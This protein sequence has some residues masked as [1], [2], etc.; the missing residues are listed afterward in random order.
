M[1][2]YS[3]MPAAK[4]STVIATW[5]T[6]DED[7]SAQVLSVETTDQAGEVARLLSSISE[8]AWYATAWLDA[9]PQVEEAISSFVGSLRAD[10]ARVQPAELD[11]AS[12]RHGD[13][14]ALEWLTGD[15]GDHG[16]DVLGRLNRAQRLSVADELVADAEGRRTWQE[17]RPSLEHVSSVPDSDRVWQIATVPRYTGDGF[18]GARADAFIRRYLNK[19]GSNLIAIERLLVRDALVRLD[20]LADACERAGGRFDIDEL[21]TYLRARYR[22]TLAPAADPDDMPE[23]ESFSVTLDDRPSRHLTIRRDRSGEHGTDRGRVDARD[24]DALAAAMGDW[25]R[26]VPMP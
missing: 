20:A 23:E 6:N 14:L 11:L 8:A 25:T 12:S 19:Y 1:T 3:V 7:R 17:H 9:H 24:D 13:A 10:T 22:F 4:K 2:T 21:G 16:T 5:A 18:S 15:L 26:L